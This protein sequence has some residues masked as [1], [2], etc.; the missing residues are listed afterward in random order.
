VT[1]VLAVAALFITA[2]AAAQPTITVGSLRGAV[3]DQASEPVVG[4]VVVATSPSL[5][6][7]QSELTD[8]SGHYFLAALPPGTYTLAIYFGKHETIRAG[9]LVRLGSE[10]VVNVRIATTGEAIEVTGSPPLV[11]QGSTKIGV[12]LTEDYTRNIPIGRRFR[13]TVGAAAGAQED[14]YGV[15][16]A[17]TTSPETTYIVDGV[18]A[19]DPLYSV[20]G[21]DLPPE[22]IAET[23]VITGGYGAEYR[24]ATGGIVNVITKQGGNAMHGSVFAY[25][26][27]GVLTATARTIQSEGGSIDSRT[28]LDAAYD[29]G[30]ELGGPIVKDK[31]WFHVGFNPHITRLTTTRTISQQLDENQDGFADVDPD[32]GFTIHVPV[33]SSRIATDGETYY[34]TSKLT[35]ALDEHHRWQLT[36]FGNPTRANELFDI[37]RNPNDVTR[38]RERGSYDMAGRWTSKLDSRL[39]WMRTSCTATLLSWWS[40]SRRPMR[41]GNGERI[42]PSNRF[43]SRFAF[44]STP[45]TNSFTPLVRPEPSQVTNKCCHS[46]RFTAFPVERVSILLLEER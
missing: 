23:E 40:R 2:R 6:G 10:A 11:D 13:D 16:I 18:V 27:P 3:I 7:T 9:I 28:D 8:T 33:T 35:G 31:L 39:R 25:F 20:L 12:T 29:I 43:S 1:R 4:A 5:Q 42:L 41:S 19:N 24:R 37:T 26:K 45:F 36:A 38:R 30:T 14:Q 15:S 21:T 22:F 44:T 46:P 17:G 32:T 34:F